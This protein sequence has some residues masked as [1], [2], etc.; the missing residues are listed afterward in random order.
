MEISV[1]IIT[2]DECSKLERCLKSIRRHIANT[3]IILVD[4]GSK[5]RTKKMAIKYTDKIFDYKWN[6]DFSEARNFSISK[7]S[8]DWILILDSDEWILDFDVQKG[9][10]LK[11][12]EDALGFILMKDRRGNEEENDLFEE[13][14]LRFFN[15]NQYEF[16]GKIHE[17]IVAKKGK[18]GP[19]FDFPIRIGHDGYFLTMDE[20]KRKADRNIQ[21]LQNELQGNCNRCYVLYQLAK[22]YL[23]KYDTVSAIHYFELCLQ[24]KVDWN[25]T[26]MQSLL[27]EYG[28]CLIEEGLEEKALTLLE[29]VDKMRIE[30]ETFFLLGYILE[31]NNLYQEAIAMYK[32]VLSFPKCN[33]EGIN[34]YKTYYRMACVLVKVGEYQL[35]IQLLLKCGDYA[36]AVKM[37]EKAFSS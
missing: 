29:Y 32:K 36:P 18:R 37:L 9:F 8:N 17:Q 7:A 27:N 22:G 6:S 20:R 14:L 25:E 4:T 11:V 24:E 15:K 33:T 19:G 13:K 34:S 35:A 23:L 12:N 31:K 16:Q 30:A 1:C 5:D 28:H 3:E 2:K 21:M 10:D 26:Y